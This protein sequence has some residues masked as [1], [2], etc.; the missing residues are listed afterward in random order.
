MGSEKNFLKDILSLKR[1]NLGKMIEHILYRWWVG[2][3]GPMNYGSLRN[4][5]VRKTFMSHFNTG[6]HTLVAGKFPSLH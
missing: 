2:M 4:P 5:G 1:I 6:N 3:G